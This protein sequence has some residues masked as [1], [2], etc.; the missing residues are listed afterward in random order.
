MTL[1][2][3]ILMLALVA[4]PVFA[5][6][7][8]TRDMPIGLWQNPKGTLRVRTMACGDAL[9]GAI[10]AATPVAEADA[11]DAGIDK[12]VGIELLKDYRK[13][14]LDR[15]AGTVYVPDMGHSFSSRIQR[16]APDTLKISGCLIGGFLCKSQ[17]WKR[18]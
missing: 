11:R 14:G 16:L 18:V 6:T 4:T 1:R 9:C 12:L 3:L 10:A 13:I 7:T 17:I 5:G 15:W 8:A 2:L